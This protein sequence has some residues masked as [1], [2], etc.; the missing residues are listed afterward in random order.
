MENG[1]K[2]EVILFAYFVKNGYLYSIINYKSNQ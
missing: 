2:M 1:V